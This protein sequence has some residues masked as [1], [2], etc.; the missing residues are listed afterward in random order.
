MS[1][2]L[3]I[4]ISYAHADE[5][6]KNELTTMMALLKRQGWV[7]SWDDRQID[8]GSDWRADIMKGMD[9]CDLALL[10]IS[11]AFL[12]SDF[13]QSVEMTHL[14]ARRKRDGIR[15]VPII[16]RPCLWHLD[17]IAQTQGLPK[18]GK[19][20][21]TFRQD[22]GERDQVWTDIGMK[23]MEWAEAQR[24]AAASTAS[25]AAASPAVKPSTPA[26]SSGTA[27]LSR[28]AGLAGT[29]GLSGS[30]G[31]SDMPN[32]PLAALGLT[33][34]NP[35]TLQVAGWHMRI[36]GVGRNT[37]LF[38][39]V[40]DGMQGASKIESLMTFCD[41]AEGRLRELWAS[42]SG[43]EQ[44]G[45]L[46]VLAG[47]PCGMGPLKLRG[48]VGGDGCGG[49]A[50]WGSAGEL[51]AGDDMREKAEMPGYWRFVWLFWMQPVTLHYCLLECGVDKPG[52]SVGS[53]GAIEKCLA[54]LIGNI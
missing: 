53:G 28:T 45:L 2:P 52:N 3:H 12:A 32:D 24:Q 1:Q 13:I 21:I 23:I 35:C 47:Q 39:P 9:R 51:A 29:A 40:N 26:G 54:Q 48:L 6:F 10:L 25:V 14:L 37:G 41:E 20:V 11:P 42:L 18:D 30:A 7:K 36:T 4:F 31:A 33:F 5:S 44:A 27:G 15:V 34:S 43:K 16:V 46:R 49:S 22:N 19:A 8:A 17:D 38:L 50:V